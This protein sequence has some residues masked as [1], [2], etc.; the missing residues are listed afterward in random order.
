MLSMPVRRHLFDRSFSGPRHAARH[1]VLLA[2]AALALV[3]VLAGC[4]SDGV[5]DRGPAGPPGP[6]GPPGED[7][8][9]EV[10]VATFTL[11]DTF[12][13]RDGR[14]Q[15]V[16][17]KRLSDSEDE[18]QYEADD[19]DFPE[20]R[21]ILTE[22]T[23]DGGIVLLYASDVLN[24]DG[25]VRRGWTALPLTI[26]VDIPTDE[27]PDGD[28]Q[29]DYTLLTTYTFDIGRLFVNFQASDVI[30]IAELENDGD[31]ASRENVLF[32]LV[33]IPGDGGFSRRA[34]DYSDYE[35]VKQA[36]NLPD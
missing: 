15:F 1:S 4:D 32:R 25:L 33:A 28:F 24:E 36:Y 27:F 10:R 13:D 5:S 20:L 18:V 31:I 17:T 21:S 23:V 14:E 34:I 2:L 19:D 6:V 29:V 26:G 7:G 11:N 30:T 22:R 3:F 16:F 12:D 8:R 9:A 35:A